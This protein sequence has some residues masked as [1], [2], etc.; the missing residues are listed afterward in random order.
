MEYC[1]VVWDGLCDGTLSLELEKLQRECSRIITG[2]TAHCCVE[3]LYSESGLVALK[4]RRRQHRLIL[5]FKIIH[6]V[7]PFALSSLLPDLINDRDSRQGR[8]RMYFYLG[9]NPKLEKF[10]KTFFYLTCDEWNHLDLDIRTCESLFTFKRLVRGP[11]TRLPTLV[12]LPR[13]TSVIYS[14]LKCGCSS[15]N[16]DLH[17]SNLI[18]VSRCG[19][20]LAAETLFHFLYD[21]PYYDVPRENLMRELDEFGALVYL[22]QC[23]LT[24]LLL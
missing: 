7:V 1:S 11:P 19:C 24:V 13:Y 16:Y 10:K 22:L 8:R 5:L 18:P 14:R 20:R 23:C 2:L 6:N 4:N 3:H 12:E 17:K 9:D 21:C 15:L